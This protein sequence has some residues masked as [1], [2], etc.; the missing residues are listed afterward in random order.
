MKKY[1]VIAYLFIT[2]FACTKTEH[3]TNNAITQQLLE[4]NYTLDEPVRIC[5]SLS[6]QLAHAPWSKSELQLPHLLVVNPGTSSEHQ[7]SLGIDRSPDFL[8]RMSGINI[9]EHHFYYAHSRLLTYSCE[10]NRLVE[11]EFIFPEDYQPQ[12][13]QSG[14]I[15]SLVQI[16]STKLQLDIVDAGKM[17][18]LVTP[19]SIQQVL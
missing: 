16:D 1:I 19:T 11:V 8:F 10:K 7:I 15:R 4:K 14:M 6:A 2:L 13:A 12:D 5:S 17:D 18:F 9:G 3:V